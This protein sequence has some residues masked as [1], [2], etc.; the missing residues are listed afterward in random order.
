MLPRSQPNSDPNSQGSRAPLQWDSSSPIR[1]PSTR[2]NPN[3]TRSSRLLNTRDSDPFEF[4]NALP[5]PSRNQPE[6]ENQN[7]RRNSQ[8][9]NRPTDATDSTSA[10]VQP[11]YSSD[12]I[13]N[14]EGEETSFLNWRNRRERE[15]SH[16]TNGEGNVEGASPM[17]Q[18]SNPLDHENR[19]DGGSWNG[20]YGSR[21]GL[22]DS[23]EASSSP[24]R[25]GR[26][27]IVYPRRDGREDRSQGNSERGGYL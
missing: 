1:N 11:H 9:E 25:G 6:S 26:T 13:V 24:S 12:P 19:N 8:L 27:P 5:S 18:I 15:E 17:N 20:N 10:L 2:Q 7:P 22:L 21:R 14:P 16:S 23:N 3:R 4:E